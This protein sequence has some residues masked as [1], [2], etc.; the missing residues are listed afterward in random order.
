[1]PIANNGCVDKNTIIILYKGE[2]LQTQPSM[3]VGIP[4]HPFFYNFLF[5]ICFKKFWNQSSDQFANNVND[6][7]TLERA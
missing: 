5:Y 2:T 3:P 6:L 7:C 1:M 4:Q